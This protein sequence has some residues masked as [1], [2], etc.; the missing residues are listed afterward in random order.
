MPLTTEGSQAIYV[1]DRCGKRQAFM[2]GTLTIR[3]TQAEQYG[4]MV[5][6]EGLAFTKYFC[7]DCAMGTKAQG[8]LL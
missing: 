6:N 3:R 7:R 8:K 1:C 2:G 4:W 5:N